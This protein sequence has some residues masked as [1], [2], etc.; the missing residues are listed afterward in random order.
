MTMKTT[1]LFTKLM[2]ILLNLSLMLVILMGIFSVDTLGS[3]VLF[4]HSAILD[5]YM[6]NL[7][8]RFKFCSWHRILI[9][10][11]LLG[12]IIQYVMLLFDVYVD[13][14][15]LFSVIGG[16]WI[17]SAITSTILYFKYGCCK[18]DESK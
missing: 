16:L 5:L 14:I 13:A 9:I 2:P 1:V 4:G 10:N 12:S 17:V 7:S 18:I 11:L 3:D 6:M 8:K 15:T